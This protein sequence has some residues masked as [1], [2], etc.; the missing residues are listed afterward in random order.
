MWYLLATSFLGSSHGFI[1]TPILLR[2][3]FLP[4]SLSSHSVEGVKTEIINDL[5]QSIENAQTSSQEW[6]D[7]FG[8]TES[9]RAFYALFEGIRK[10][11]PLGLRGKPFVI[12]QA[13]VVHA[14]NLANPSPF[15]GYF[16]FH[17]L[18][19][20]ID[21]NFLDAGR[22]STDNRKGW[23]VR[24]NLTIDTYRHTLQFNQIYY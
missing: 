16:T 2:N 10:S 9:E 5:L 4:A 21:E 8:L 3:T 24:I 22:G 17:D 1:S 6:T 20:A 19:K 15:G 14:L 23:K 12:S 7:M 18:A 13:D 11:V